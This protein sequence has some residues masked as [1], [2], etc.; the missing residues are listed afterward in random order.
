ME[1]EPLVV[2]HPHLKEFSIFLEKLRSESD[3]GMVLISTGYLEEQLKQ[4]LLSF[5]VDGAAQ[6]S[7]FEGGN[8]PLGTF[9]A[10]TSMCHALGLIS[11]QE[12]DDL[13]QLRR[14]RNDFA[15]SI[16]TT[17]ETQSVMNRCKTLKAKANDYHSPT[18][19]EVVVSPSGQFSSA[20]TA[21]ILNMVNRPHYVGKERLKYKT[22][23]Y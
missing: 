6:D 23:E 12:H 14:I 22:W 16:H 9:S 13:H 7:L 15:H 2:N 21:I 4:V 18:L 17:F 5:F 20:A 1:L 11:K 10:R 19:G 8:A 3:R